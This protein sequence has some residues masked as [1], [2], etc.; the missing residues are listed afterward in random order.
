MKPF[1][2]Q[3]TG[4]VNTFAIRFYPHGF[5]HLTQGS[6]K[7]LV[8]TETHINQ[9]FDKDEAAT[10]E[11]EIIGGAETLDRIKIIEAFLFRKLNDRATIDKNCFP[12]PSI[13]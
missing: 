2:I 9:L 8:N 10:L 1:Y 6:I 3:P 7:A 12:Q 11:Q 5:S 4:Y 13:H